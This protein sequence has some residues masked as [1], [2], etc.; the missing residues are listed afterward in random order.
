MLKERISNNTSNTRDSERDGLGKAHKLALQLH[1]R[2]LAYH[3]TIVFE[4]ID[5]Q[6][7]DMLVDRR[8]HGTNN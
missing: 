6:A 5:N 7:M 3:N 1:S 8:L 4:E 2:A